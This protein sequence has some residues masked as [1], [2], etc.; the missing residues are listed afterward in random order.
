M[1]IKIIEYV[2]DKKDSFENMCK[3]YFNDDL[4]C[5]WSEKV[6][7]NKIFKHIE[8]EL[9]DNVIAICIVEKDSES[10][11]F[12]IYQIDTPKSDWCKKRGWGFI[13]EAYIKKEFRGCGY[14]RKL[15]EYIENDFIAMNIH[16]LYLQ[17]DE[18]M[19]FW[20]KCK[21]KD[22]GECDEEGMHTLIKDLSEI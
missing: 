6:F 19:E 18:A 8:Q 11:G 3:T 21:Y 15:V 22:N 10:I 9:A 7:R 13:R 1:S 12:A 16:N 5:G 2:S 4:H 20:L 14:G 17:A